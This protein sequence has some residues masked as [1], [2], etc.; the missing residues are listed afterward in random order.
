[1]SPEDRIV[2]LLSRWLAR[3]LD[4]EQ[5]RAQLEAAGREGLSVEQAEAVDELLVE[6]AGSSRA[7]RGGPRAA[8]PRDDGS[9]C[10]RLAAD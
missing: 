8:G 7:G 10:A 1:M 3:H 4:N 6:L 2:S 5:L 9:A